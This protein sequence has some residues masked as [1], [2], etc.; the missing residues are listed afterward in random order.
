MK[1]LALAARLVPAVVVLA[2][3][4]IGTYG[5][6][7]LRGLPGVRA[8]AVHK[9]AIDTGAW[10]YTAVVDMDAHA[11]RDQVAGAL[12]GLARWYQG[13]H[14]EE[15][16]VRLYVGGDTVAVRDGWGDDGGRGPNAIITDA[17]SHRQNVA[18]AAVLLRAREVFD[19]PVTVRG[20]GW[21]VLTPQP[22]AALRT[23]LDHPELAKVPGADLHAPQELVPDA[24]QDDWQL[25]ASFGSSE[26]VR[27]QHLTTYDKA[28]A[29]ARLVRGARARVNFVG[30]DPGVDPRPTDTHPGAIEIRMDLRLPGMAGPRELAAD[31]LA[32]P[33][34]PMIRAQLD[35]LRTLPEGSR[36][37]ID[38]E[39]GK[40]PEGGPGG[41]RWLVDLGVGQKK[42]GRPHGAWQQAAFEYL[43]R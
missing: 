4:G 27:R 21:T 13:D 9:Q 30:S 20:Y 22:R 35:L 7:D 10:S 18:S 8:A 28:V 2:A 17:G 3:C 15:D 11:T 6:D 16:G 29:N 5:V 34:W 36:F 41:F 19:A 37:S 1:R 39:W 42:P 32:D 25:P 33:R 38:L 26:A 12:D 40:A 14:G 23:L 43:N 31:P 24:P